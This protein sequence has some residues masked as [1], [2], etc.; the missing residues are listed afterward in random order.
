MVTKEVKISL[1]VKLY[2]SG[3]SLSQTAQACGC[4]PGRVHR[5]LDEAGVKIRPRGRPAK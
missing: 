5:I 3:K 1:V 2:Q 4:S